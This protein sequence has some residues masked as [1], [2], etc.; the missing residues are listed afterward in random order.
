MET[1]AKEQNMRDWLQDLRTK[2]F[3][4]KR[5]WIVCHSSP[6]HP[7]YLRTMERKRQPSCNS[8]NT[9]WGNLPLDIQ[10]EQS[11]PDR[12]TS[13]LEGL[14]RAVQCHLLEQAEQ[15]EFGISWLFSHYNFVFSCIQ[16]CSIPPKKRMACILWHAPKL[17]LISG[18][19]GMFSVMALFPQSLFSK[20]EL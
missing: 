10:R 20:P 17:G 11:T 13:D 4:S 15:E 7:Q 9:F 5:S 19:I 6:W 3:H 1:R 12:N 8:L 18:I 14:F 16:A 2:Q